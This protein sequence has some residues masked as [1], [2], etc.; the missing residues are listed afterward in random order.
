M[1]AFTE[2]ALIKKLNELNSSQQ[3]I[4]TLSLWLIHHRKHHVG[5]IKTW[6]RELQ[7]APQSKKLTFMYLANDVIQNSKK[8][9]PEYGKE[10]G[11]VLRKVFKHINEH[12]DEEKLFM[13]VDRILKIW[14]DRGVYDLDTIK[15]FRKDL[16]KTT[17][18]QKFK[19]P[20]V[21]EKRSHDGSNS[22]HSKKSRIQKE[23]KSEH[24]KREKNRTETVEINGKVETHVTLSPHVPVGDP[25]EPQELIKALSDLENSASSDAVVRERIAN[26]PPEISELSNLSKVED[27]E[28][29]YKLIEQVNEAVQLLNDYNT[30]LAAEMEDRKK[31]TVMLRDFQAEQRELLVQAEQRLEEFTQ[32]LSKMKAVQKEIRDH[33]SNLPDLT[34]LPD[35]T[36]GLAPLPSAG[37]LFNVH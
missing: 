2:S 35:V 1:S 7:K 11:V 22:V 27:K 5:I 21:G 34:Q 4:Q 3:S 25:P 19:K 6:Y 10:F 28:T 17:E 31:L 36:G 30:R 20:E 15:E 32:K 33:L 8:K 23:H 24:E 9:G 12:C 37:D 14:E 13:N 18:P 26:L 29:A 16:F